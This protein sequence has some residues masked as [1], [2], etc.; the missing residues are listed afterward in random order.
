MLDEFEVGDVGV[1]AVSLAESDT[2]HD[3]TRPYHRVGVMTVNYFA[4]GGTGKGQLDPA[5]VVIG[6]GGQHGRPR[7]QLVARRELVR[8]FEARRAGASQGITPGPPQR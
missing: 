5:A 4:E 2:Q 1:N 3:K 8:L 6:L 7:F